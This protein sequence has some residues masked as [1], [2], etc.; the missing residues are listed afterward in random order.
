MWDGPRLERDGYES[1][2]PRRADE[3]AR[4]V[5]LPQVQLIR[6]VDLLSLD[7]GM[8]AAAVFLSRNECSSWVQL[9]R[10][11]LLDGA[12]SGQQRTFNAGAE[13]GVLQ[14]FRHH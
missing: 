12:E 9:L 5:V 7:R 11:L 2:C 3:P 1:E 10:S 4:I 14:P 13:A 6:P 8:F